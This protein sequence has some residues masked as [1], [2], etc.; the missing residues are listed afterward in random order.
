MFQFPLLF[1]VIVTALVIVTVNSIFSGVGDYGQYVKPVEKMILPTNIQVAATG[2]THTDSP[3]TARRVA[4]TL[5]DQDTPDSNKKESTKFN[6]PEEH[7]AISKPLN[8]VLLYGDDWRHD[9]IGSAKA[10]IVKTPFF[11]WMATQGIKFVHNCVTTS[12]CWISRATLYTGLYVSRHKSDYP[13]KPLWYEGWADAW[14]KLLQEKG[15][16]LGHIG[17]WHFNW[18]KLVWDTFDYGKAY[19]GK[20]FFL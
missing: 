10:S 8:I 12:V 14:P 7:E 13:H 17:K 4:D 18:E 9:S 16:Y 3:D 2:G 1:G 6:P 5:N 19:Y 15:Y 11:D 20:K